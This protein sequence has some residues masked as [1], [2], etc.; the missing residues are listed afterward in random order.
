LIRRFLKRWYRRPFWLGVVVIV[1]IGAGRLALT[2]LVDS[3]TRT[4]LSQLPNLHVT[5]RDMSIFTLPASVVLTD[6]VARDRGGE[7][8]LSVPRLEV[9]FSWRDAVAG[10][11]AG[12]WPYPAPHVRVRAV[13]P[14]LQL[15][16]PAPDEVVAQA[17]AMLQ[18]LPAMHADVVGLERTRVS[19]LPRA[20]HPA[21][22]C[23]APFTTALQNV[24]L[25][26]AA[27]P[28]PLGEE[29]P[30][31][32]SVARGEVKIPEICRRLARGSKTAQAVVSPAGTLV[33]SS[34]GSVGTVGH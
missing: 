4:Q 16:S 9:H 1:L 22:D 25:G 27:E 26:A 20:G 14:W 13:Q 32:P 17:R 23:G 34:L 8:V 18:G 30:R 29:P 12:A 15:R 21:Q 33:T 3:A 6:V 5:Y 10:A 24:D 31:V 7:R 2:P 28:S 11:L 19:L